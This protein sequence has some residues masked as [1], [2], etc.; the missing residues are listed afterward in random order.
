[1]S[2]PLLIF[3]GDCR[4]CTACATWAQRRLRDADVVPGQRV[5]VAAYGLTAKDVSAAAWWVDDR[6]RVYRG[7]RAI[8]KALQACGGWWRAV[9]WLCLTPPFS[10]VAWAV[11]G[12][13][14]RLASGTGFPVPRPP[15]SPPTTDL[16]ESDPCS[17][18]S[19][20]PASLRF[21]TRKA[22]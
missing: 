18:R 21:S 13:V 7:H 10:W 22:G 17:R 12:L 19:G 5:D 1:M 8:G 6:R 3:D 20:Q 15:A 11:Y 9:S 16:S 14:A 4:F 2:R